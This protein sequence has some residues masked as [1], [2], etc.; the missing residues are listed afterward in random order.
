M[1]NQAEK[2]SSIMSNKSE[3]STN[4]NTSKKIKSEV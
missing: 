2:Y 4:N 1:S 3:N